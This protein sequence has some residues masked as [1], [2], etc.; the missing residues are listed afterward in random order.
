MNNVREE[1]LNGT[2]KIG[3]WGCGFIGF[4]SMVNFAA[5][6]IRCIGYD[7][8]P[9]LVENINNG[10]I[11][12]PNLE[13]WLGFD[14]S[15]L[16]NSGMIKATNNWKELMTK[17]IAV[18]LIAIPTEKGDKPWDGALVDVMEKL[19]TKEKDSDILIIIE[20]TLTPD[21]TE[22]IVIPI[23]KKSGHNVGRNIKIGVAPR[24]DWFISPEKSLKKLPRIIG[25]TNTETTELMR[26]VL[27]IICD[28]IHAAS[29]HKHAELVKSIENAYR[30]M[31]ITLAN[32]LSNAYP[33]I[34]MREVLRLV[35]TKWNIGTYH[36][37]F[38]TGGYCIPLSSQYVLEGAPKPEK[39]TL[40]KEAIDTDNAQPLLV[41]EAI[42]KS[43]S[44]KVGV[45]GLSYK[46]DLKVHI[47]SPTL[48]IA[49][50]LKKQGIE[51]KVHDP[52]YTEDEIEK[53]TGTK[54]FSFPE[55]LKEFD[56]IIIVADHKYYSALPNDEILKNLENCNIVLDNTNIWETIN[57]SR[58]NIRYYKAGD[59]EWLN[60]QPKK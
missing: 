25:G 49:N 22:K 4:S 39:L 38:G 8:N 24:R 12:L 6:G 28:T 36:P 47:L 34:N 40:L 41:A 35:G 50:S 10:K 21:R 51:V 45:L 37:S 46:G 56:T 14:T 3:V 29:D 27:G 15:P 32:Q 11:S 13:Y 30:H 9:D 16:M 1:L 31:E 52:Y 55:G 53:I 5:N 18:H 48:R 58:S 44:K 42:K 2:K 23:F 54:S 17:D 33:D 7:I 59:A 57:F 26:D 20:S 60:L 43:G 19:A